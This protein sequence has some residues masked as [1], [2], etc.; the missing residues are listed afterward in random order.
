MEKKCILVTGG[1]DPLHSGHIQYFKSAKKIC[2]YLIVGINSDKWLVRKK[3]VYFYT[4]KERIN[5]LKELNFVDKVIIFNDDD[6][7]ASNAIRQCL[8]ISEKVIFANG[9]DR[10]KIN[11]PEFTTFKNDSRVEF[12][13]NVGGSKKINSSSNILK[14][15]YLR[16][17]AKDLAE[18]QNANITKKPWGCYKILSTGE[19]YKIKILEILPNEKISLQY[20]K[21]R[22]EHW[23]VLN[24]IAE[25]QLEDNIKKLKKNDEIFIPKRSKHRVSNNGVENL[26]IIEVSLGEYIEEDDIVRLKDEYNRK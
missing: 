16:I 23:I 24:G 11:I 19:G 22:S 15:Y 5:I 26:K 21:E 2:K 17:C 1:F 9:G 25:V 4:I 12:L 3:G 18:D 20:H 13:F 14:D 6:N 10:E 8:K 7:S